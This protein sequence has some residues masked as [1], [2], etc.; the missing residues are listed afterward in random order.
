[1]YLCLATYFLDF[2]SVDYQVNSYSIVKVVVKC[3]P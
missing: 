3:L 1:M 2:L